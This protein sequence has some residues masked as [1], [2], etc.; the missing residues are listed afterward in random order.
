MANWPKATNRVVEGYMAI[1]FGPTYNTAGEAE[2]GMDY[3][4]W[5]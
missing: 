5:H 4:E 1:M 3:V 2:R